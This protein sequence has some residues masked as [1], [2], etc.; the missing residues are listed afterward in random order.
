MGP[1]R[2]IRQTTSDVQPQDFAK[3]AW[4]E[5]AYGK[6]ILPSHPPMLGARHQTIIDITVFNES[7]LRVLQVPPPKE[8]DVVAEQLESIAKKIQTDTEDDSGFLPSKQKR[9]SMSSE[10][11][12]AHAF[13]RTH[14]ILVSLTLAVSALQKIERNKY[15]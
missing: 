11:V 15:V 12:A 5:P 3:R 14:E 9:R 1:A 8:L 13:H 6:Q 10:S 7:P 2:T 4:L